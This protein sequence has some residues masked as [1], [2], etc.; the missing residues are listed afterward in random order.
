M[1][2]VDPEGQTWRVSRRWVPWRR[3]LKADAGPD[4]PTGSM[5]DD[6]I[7][8]ILGLVV[9]VIALPFLI[10]TGL[11]LLELLLLVLLIPFVVLGR[12]VFGRQWRIEVRKGW[13]PVWEGDA[14]SWSESG[15]AIERVATALQQGLGVTKAT[16]AVRH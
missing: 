11:A 15:Q 13:T 9:L 5:G 1:K 2:V 12:I 6:P 10:I 8:M 16:Q 3:R 7:S 4:L 14:G